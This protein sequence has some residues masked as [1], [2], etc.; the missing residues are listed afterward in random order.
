MAASTSSV[1][2]LGRAADNDLVVA[3]PSVS[4]HH[5]ELHFDGEQ[6]LLRDLSS[7]NGTFVNGERI[8]AATLQGGDTVHLGP[9]ALK[10]D[11]G[12]L[13]IHVELEP[14]DLTPDTKTNRKPALVAVL[15]LVIG[16]A[17]AVPLLV[18][19][20]DDTDLPAAPVTTAPESNPST[21]TVPVTTAVPTTSRASATTA[22]PTT[23]TVASTTT[24]APTTTVVPTTAVPTITAPATTAS[25]TTTT[26]SPAEIAA[27]AILTAN[28]QWGFS[29]KTGRLQALLAVTADGFYGYETRTA[30]KAELA[31]RGLPTSGVPTP[32]PPTT[33]T[34]APTTTVGPTTTAPPT[35]TTVAATTTTV[36]ATTTSPPAEN[37]PDWETLARSVVY[38]WVDYCGGYTW[39]G[40]GTI[41]LDGGYVLT[42]AHVVAD[43]YGNF[44][45]MSIYAADSASEIPLWFADGRVIP[46]AYNSVVDLAVIKLVDMNGFP[47]RAIGRDPIEIRNIE[48]GLGDEIK[49]LGY[50][51]MGGDM[52]TMTSGEQSGWFAGQGGDFYKTSAK[53]GPGVSGGAAFDAHTGEFV[54]V[55]TAGTIVDSGD[56]LGLIRPNSY[57]FQL[58]VA[59][60][61]S[62]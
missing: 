4:A 60:E 14:D 18:Q 51:G 5:A 35:T 33:T 61:Q 50:P 13:Q 47:T 31:N 16:L 53:G 12:Q 22:T 34:V 59:A 30:H 41:V 19:Q 43:D 11:N 29:G 23:M 10:F 37:A 49:V 58:L 26:E 57:I 7:S 28:Y 62:G 2:K 52:I 40:S 48:L 27:K 54:G 56:T 9:V 20:S 8:T 3:H 17:V 46:A 39:S 44:C 45:D 36:A 24:A 55:P 6:F 1:T 25:P 32:P 21:S 38:I 42:N 15:V